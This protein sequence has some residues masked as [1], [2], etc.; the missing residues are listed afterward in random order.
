MH[1]VD[2]LTGQVAGLLIWDLVLAYIYVYVSSCMDVQPILQC[3]F[4][5][6]FELGQIEDWPFRSNRPRSTAYIAY[7]QHK[8]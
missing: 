4:S 1:V 6:L 8:A 3:A 2:R 7:A 5:I